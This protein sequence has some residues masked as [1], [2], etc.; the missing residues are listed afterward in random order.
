MKIIS[1]KL[2]FPK[3]PI[4]LSEMLERAQALENFLYRVAYDAEGN[5]KSSEAA[6]RWESVYSLTNF[7]K[8][9]IDKPDLRESHDLLAAPPSLRLVGIAEEFH[10]ISRRQAA[11]LRHGYADR[12]N[13][14]VGVKFT[15]AQLESFE[16]FFKAENP[17]SLKQNTEAVTDFG[18]R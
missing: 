3:G 17:F 14:A 4:S 6:Q 1:N 12:F 11:S 10:V 5:P 9:T 7:L 15:P 18:V 13:Q 8:S 2:R 16:S